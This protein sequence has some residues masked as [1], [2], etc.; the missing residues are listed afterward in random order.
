MTGRGESRAIS[1]RHE[2]RGKV[3]EC[4]LESGCVVSANSDRQ[5]RAGAG[6]QNT[7]LGIGIA[8]ILALV[9]ALVGP[10]FVNWNAHRAYFEAEA[11][12]L[13]GLPV[14]V[15]GAIDA[16]LLP[17]PSITLRSIAIGDQGDAS[18]VRAGALAFALGLG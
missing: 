15:N 6:V 10:I 14:Q 11:T 3:C 1:A 7:L 2:P 16:R 13:V 18:R 12:R 9:A 5:K 17:T 8:L 4:F